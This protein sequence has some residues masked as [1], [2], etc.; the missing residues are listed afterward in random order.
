MTAPAA[1]RLAAT[2]L[3]A[4]AFAGCGG[5]EEEGPQIPRGDASALINRLEEAQRRSDPFRCNDLRKD[6]LPALERQLAALPENVDPDVRSTV[7][8]GIAHLSRL[9][10]EECELGQQTETETTPT[11]PSETPTTPPPTETEPEETTPA[12]TTP[13]PAPEP[14]P[15]AP[16]GGGTPAPDD[17]SGGAAVPGTGNGKKPKGI[18]G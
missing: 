11:A 16:G 10:D 13:E 7:E 8:D 4:L 6:T 5:E 2:A 3:A 18:D 1:T 17:G 15:E 14:E 9:V 12:P